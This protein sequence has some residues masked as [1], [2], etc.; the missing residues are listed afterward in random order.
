[1]IIW[2]KESKRSLV[3]AHACLEQWHTSQMP[4]R[5]R[6]VNH[7]SEDSPRNKLQNKRAAG[8]AQVVLGSITIAEKKKKKKRNEEEWYTRF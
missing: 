7:E 5:Q 1:M 4:R 3:A 6:Q 8:V 2:K